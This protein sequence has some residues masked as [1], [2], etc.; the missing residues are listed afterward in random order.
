VRAA[1]R[2]RQLAQ[3]ARASRLEQRGGVLLRLLRDQREHGAR[4]LARARVVVLVAEVGERLDDVG[5]NVQA[6]EVRAHRRQRGERML[7]QLLLVRVEQRH[8]RRD[9]RRLDHEVDVRLV[10]RERVQDAHRLQLRLERVALEEGHQRVGRARRAERRSPLLLVRQ[11]P[12]HAQPMDAR[13]LALAV[14]QLDDRL[15]ARR[16]HRRLARRHTH[17]LLE[18]RRGRVQ[19]VHADL[20]APRRQHARGADAAAQQHLH[21]ARRLRDGRRVRLPRKAREHQRRLALRLWVA[22]LTA[23]DGDER[24][25][26]A[27]A[28]DGLLRL[29]VAAQR[30]QAAHSRP[31]LLGA[32][33][34]LL[35]EQAHR[36]L[37]ARQRSHGLRVTAARQRV[38]RAL[39]PLLRLANGARKLD[40]RWKSRA[41]RWVAAVEVGQAANRAHRLQLPRA[42]ARLHQRH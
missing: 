25:D 7:G 10:L 9:A 26:A 16:Q 19:R 29:R 18:R 24:T 31:L 13:R 42:A 11:L 1:A 40:E 3:A 8:E 34:Q 37:V 5:R 20:L 41:Q 22:V 32:A 33:A 4:V 21:S 6:L 28:H 30:A 38:Q 23:G 36:T 2:Q 17:Q 39:R 12:K 14:Q 27:A 15:D 35:D